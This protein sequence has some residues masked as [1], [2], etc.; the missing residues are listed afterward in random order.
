MSVVEKKKEN[1]KSKW[2][3]NK[4]VW[5]IIGAILLF[6][7]NIVC[8]ILFV[9]SLT[10]NLFTAISGW[11]SGI[12]TACIGVIAYWQNKRESN[13]SKDIND[14]FYELQK[15]IKEL[16]SQMYLLAD[17]K[18]TPFISIKDQCD[19]VVKTISLKG[20]F[21]KKPIL[22]SEKKVLERKNG[23][24]VINDAIDYSNIKSERRFFINNESRVKIKDI[25]IRSIKFLC[26]LNDDIAVFI[27]LVDKLDIEICLNSGSTIEFFV[28]L[29][30]NN[31]SEY[32]K[33]DIEF[34]I[35]LKNDLNQTYLSNYKVIFTK[36]FDSKSYNYHSG[37]YV[38]YP[39]K[40]NEK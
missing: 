2:Y 34:D 13:K 32:T 26:Y 12:A 9:S 21:D 4:W 8:A 20:N 29:P 31:R 16:S 23:K 37:T 11:V 30:Y 18:E 6:A 1:A 24:F 25:N 39:T 15:N 33:I 36:N 27:Y 14:K 5:I 3:K 22:A 40:I 38:N 28:E 17:M 19:N 10:T 7:A 35:E